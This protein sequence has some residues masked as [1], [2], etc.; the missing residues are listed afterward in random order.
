VLICLARI[1]T[2]K[3]WLIL[4]FNKKIILVSFDYK[5]FHKV[6]PIWYYI[7]MKYIFKNNYNL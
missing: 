2:S 3:F 7:Y 6:L 4:E 5:Y 1:K